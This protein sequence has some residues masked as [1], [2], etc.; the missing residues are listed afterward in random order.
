M[1]LNGRYL[2]WQA[3][4]HLPSLSTKMYKLTTLMIAFLQDEPSDIPFL[5]K[6]ADSFQHLSV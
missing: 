6:K 4:T 3:L 2:F 5:V 1:L